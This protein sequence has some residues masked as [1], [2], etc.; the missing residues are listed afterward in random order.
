MTKQDNNWGF[1]GREKTM[2]D[3]GLSLDLET[4]N[5]DRRFN[6]VL[7]VGQRGIG[8]TSLLEV[9]KAK[10][11]SDMPFIIFE[12][13]NSAEYNLAE[14]IKDLLDTGRQA[15]L[16]LMSPEHYTSVLEQK[17]FKQILLTMLQQGATV[18][19]DEFHHADYKGFGLTSDIK[20]AIDKARSPA[21]Q[22]R[23]HFPGKLVMMGSHQQ[24]VLAMFA[25]DQPLY[26]RYDS[27]YRLKQWCLET[28]MKVAQE[29]GLLHLE[30]TNRFLTLWTAYGG[31]PGKWESYCTGRDYAPLHK[32][33]DLR[34]WQNE[35]LLY[36]R[37]M[38]VKNP[39]ARWDNKAYVELQPSHR[40]LL[41]WLAE[42][43]YRRVW[44]APVEEIYQALPGKFTRDTVRVLKTHLELIDKSAFYLENDKAWWRITDSNTLYQLDV[45]KEYQDSEDLEKQVGDYEVDINGD[46]PQN[47]PSPDGA[48]TSPA[49]EKEEKKKKQ[50]VY[51]RLRTLEGRTLELMTARY[52]REQ[53]GFKWA[54]PN[55][56]RNALGTR[57]IDV[58]AFDHFTLPSKS[59]LCHL[60]RNP[61]EHQV[62][63]INRSEKDFINDLQ[64]NMNEDR[65]ETVDHFIASEK[66]TVLIS[67]SFQNITAGKR[68]VFKDEG[69]KLIDIPRIARDYGI[70][71]TPKPPKAEPAP[72][73][74]PDNDYMPPEPE[75]LKPPSPQFDM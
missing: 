58:L 28:T 25:Y 23:K 75:R 65:K 35:F 1:Y 47:A 48:P 32:I 49:G 64:E 59:W 26:N 71:L 3:L 66:S 73:Q 55:V 57:D 4:G 62:S 51:E 16:K 50:S 42:S 46:V 22:G 60:K 31:I 6:S 2:N 10:A 74:E 41:H 34:N 40:E 19:L 56:G 44:G 24:R 14:V 8:K 36:E 21:H 69:Y 70:T 27:F 17:N 13:P 72:D 43:E 12:M 11:P 15:G 29:Y 39:E 68:N 20:L 63:K 52:L 33:D 30:E 18:V 37:D 67:P 54:E 7:V 53:R 61:S 38:L 9:M 5:R 45:F